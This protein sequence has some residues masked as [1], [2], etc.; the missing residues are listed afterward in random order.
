M[1]KRRRS[2]EGKKK[3]KEKK[4]NIHTQK[5]RSKK[6]KRKEN[7]RRKINGRIKI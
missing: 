3:Q 4:G 2:K 5:L 6:V 7:C 1:M